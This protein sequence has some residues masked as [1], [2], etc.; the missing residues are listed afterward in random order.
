MNGY[1]AY[2]HDM[3]GASAVASMGSAILGALVSIA[4]YVMQGIA[5]YRM[6]E[7]CGIPNGW[8][9]FIPIANVWLL[10]KIADANEITPKHAKRLLI[11]EI[12]TSGLAI[13]LL[14][15]MAVMLPTAMMG[16]TAPFAGLS[17][18]MM[19]VSLVMIVV[20]I[21]YTVFLYIAFYR[22]CENFAPESTTGWF[23]GIL[24][25][26]LCCSTLIPPILL[27]VLSGNE[28]ASGAPKA[29]YT[30]VPPRDDVF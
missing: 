22:I 20:A 11:L 6:A 24:L 15:C 18:F 28:P 17:L 10:G 2:L 14:A 3:V 29:T 25:G 30:E 1:E 13:L 5:F 12:L 4:V 7:K 16:E 23:L 21:V 26:G 19:L 9:A 27:L 8:L